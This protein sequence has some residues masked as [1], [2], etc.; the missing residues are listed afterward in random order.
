VIRVNKPARAPA[1]LRERGREARDLL[2]KD[3]DAGG[4]DFLFDRKIYAHESVKK[5][6]RQAQHDKCC[7]CE[8]KVSHISH[9]DV[10]HFRPKAAC[11][12]RSGGAPRRP[13]YYWLAYE[14]SNLFFCCQLCNQRHKKDLFPLMNPKARAT[15]HHDDLAK[16][17]PLFLDPAGDDPESHIE[18]DQERARPRNGSRRGLVTIRALKLNRK[19]LL[20]RR[21]SHLEDLRKLHGAQDALAEILRRVRRSGRRPS[22]L[23]QSTLAGLERRLDEHTHDSAEYAVM[24]RAFLARAA[25]RARP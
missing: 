2:C 18:F 13:G 15:S 12:Q 20:A 16:E 22:D 23:Q 6:L 7:F 1:V 14:W 19:E 21:H 8:S 4:R 9:G 24:A 17:R 10:E 11:R 25:P 5:A 3:Y